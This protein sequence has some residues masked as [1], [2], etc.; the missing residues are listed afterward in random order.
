VSHFL[1][2]QAPPGAG[3]FFQIRRQFL[4]KAAVAAMHTAR[5]HAPRRSLGAHRDAAA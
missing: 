5:G 4:A 2:P 3:L 1:N